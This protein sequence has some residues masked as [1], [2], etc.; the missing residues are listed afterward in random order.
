MKRDFD[1]HIH[2]DASD[3]SYSPRDL[4]R[5]AKSEGLKTI[6][7]TDHDT[8]SG[9]REAIITGEELGVTVIPGVE[10][11][12]DF[13]PGTMHV[14]GYNIDIDSRELND[15]LKF[16]QKARRERNPKIIE[17]LNEMGI[18]ITYDDVQNAAGSDQVGR[19]HFAKVLIQKNYVKDAQEAFDKYLAKGS[20]AYVDKERLPLDDA[21]KIIDIA[22]GVAVLAHP[23]QLQLGSWQ[24]YREMISDLKNHGIKGLEAF[25]SRH[26]DDESGHFYKIAKDLDMIITCGSDFHGETKPNVHLGEYGEEVPLAIDEIIESIQLKRKNLKFKIC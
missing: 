19:P 13:N 9:V 21:I 7:I 18:D 3:G 20:S 8:V 10:I 14:C 5:L 12:I 1:L 2:T 4:V 22:G 25:S 16:V 26:T 15:S 6:A 24:K 11:S 17:K 23:I